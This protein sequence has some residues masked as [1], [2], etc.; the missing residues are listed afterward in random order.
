M[1]FILNIGNFI[2]SVFA[3]YH[4]SIIILYAIISTDIIQT[5]INLRKFKNI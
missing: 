1:S 5:D 2:S 4:Y 3:L